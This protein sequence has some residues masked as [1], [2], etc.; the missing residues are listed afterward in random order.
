MTPGWL[1]TQTLRGSASTYWARKQ[2]ICALCITLNNL[3]KLSHKLPQHLKNTP[4]PLERKAKNETNS[5]LQTQHKN[6]SYRFL[7]LPKS[8]PI[9]T[10]CRLTQNSVV[11]GCN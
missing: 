10:V 9:F 6:I 3:H 8:L 1:E 2:F 5:V 4:L 11:S 7:N